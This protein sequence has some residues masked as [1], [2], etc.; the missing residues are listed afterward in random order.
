MSDKILKLGL[1]G[2]GCVGQG[3]H[4]VLSETK[5]I[6]ATIEKICIK[7]PEK[8]RSLPEEYF[9]TNASEILDN[10]AID[11]VVE[12]IDDAEAAYHIVKTALTQG[13]AVVSANKKM[14]A[15]NLEELLWLQEKY[16]T[17]FL[18][19]GAVCG[20][21]PILRNLEEYYDNDLLSSISGIFNGSTN[22]ILSKMK[23]EGVDYSIA[24]Q[25]AQEKGFAESNPILDVGGFD[26]K[27]KLCITLLHAFGIIVRP[28][29][30]LNIGIQN[31]NDLDVQYAQQQGKVI[32]LLAHGYK[33]GSEISAFVLP[34]F[35]EEESPLY[36]VHNEFN[37][38]VV[39][40]A[41]ANEQFFWGRGAGSDP[42]GSAV[43]SDISALTYDYRYEYKKLHQ[44]LVVTYSTELLLEVY[45]RYENAKQVQWFDFESIEQRF[46]SKEYKYVIGRITLEKLLQEEW[47]LNKN[48]SVVLNGIIAD[49]KSIKQKQKSEE[50]ALAE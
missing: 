40:S 5:G 31:L 29:N 26:P 7:H 47:Q 27:Y 24:L 28:E 38:I 36:N 3:L 50:L 4:H 41:F 45:V 10:P 34:T 6:S 48:I 43:L 25:E 11:V 2:F 14:I 39:E 12:L 37:G 19:E 23:N 22:Y 15:E 13:K 42:T 1:F 49:N 30:I 17:P 44:N 35:V 16:Q 33:N 8:K 32:K 20:S 46:E 9:T 21:I 18:Y